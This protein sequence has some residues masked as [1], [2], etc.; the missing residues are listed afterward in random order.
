M[1]VSADAKGLEVKPKRWIVER[2]F[3]GI[4]RWRR[5]HAA[6]DHDARHAAKACGGDENFR[7]ASQGSMT[8]QLVT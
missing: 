8:S 2:T 4:A 3:A 1:S 5:S 7:M 6:P